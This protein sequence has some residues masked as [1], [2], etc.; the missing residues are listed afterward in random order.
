M[1]II[2]QGA[3]V[4][5][6]VYKAPIR[7]TVNKG[8]LPPVSEILNPLVPPPTY[9]PPGTIP[10]LPPGYQFP[11]AIFGATWP[12][13]QALI[14]KQRKASGFLLTAL[15]LVRNSFP[16]NLSGTAKILLG[17]KCGAKAGLIDIRNVF[18]LMVNNELIFDNISF[19]FF[20]SE[21][22]TNGFGSDY[23][24][25]PRPLSGSDNIVITIDSVAGGNITYDTI[26]YYL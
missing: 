19:A 22:Q 17:M 18:S 26:F 13:I 12:D 6:P 7:V 8:G 20:S 14:Q 11:G 3:I 9:A 2:K 15:P 16:I 24:S 25:F 23:V 21:F 4:R 5:P 1:P 10:P